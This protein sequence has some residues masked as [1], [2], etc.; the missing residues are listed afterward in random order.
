MFPVNRLPLVFCF[1]VFFISSFKPKIP[2]IMKR[3]LFYALTFLTLE[4]YAQSSLLVT[5][6]SSSVGVIA[7]ST[8]NVTT[9]I[10]NDTYVAFDI[11]N[12]SNTQKSYLVKRYDLNIH[13]TATQTANP[14]FSFGGNCYNTN[15]L[16]SVY[17]VTLTPNQYASSIG[18]D[19]HLG[20]HLDE[21]TS[22]GISRVKY[23]FFNTANASDSIQFTIQYN[24]SSTTGIT[25]LAKNQSAI[26]IYPNPSR[27]AA[28]LLFNSAVSF[29]SKLLI[30]N[31][32]GDILSEK[33]VSITE[34]KNTIKVDTEGLSAGI[35]FLRLNDGSASISKKLILEK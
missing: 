13:A 24:V 1:P 20:T 26:R 28:N 30:L 2:G 35:Y 29:N 32:L 15:V 19:Q 7:N 31:A 25:S 11:M 6:L 22:V 33:E 14:Y 5:N 16:T 21:I 23:T 27:G 17:P 34:G 10:N 9:N 4:N 18:T 3:L 8:V 12:S